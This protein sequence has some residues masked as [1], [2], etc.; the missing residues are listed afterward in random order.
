MFND[1]ICSCHSKT[2]PRDFDY[3]KSSADLQ[4]EAEEDKDSK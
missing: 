2:S 1:I 3:E 4:L